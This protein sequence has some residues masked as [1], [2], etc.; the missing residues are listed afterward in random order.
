M[1]TTP[2]KSW[3]I[4]HG[5]LRVSESG[6]DSTEIKCRWKPH[7]SVWVLWFSSTGSTEYEAISNL[8]DEVKEFMFNLMVD[9]DKD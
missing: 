4:V 9:M 6:D 7:G 5:T 8:Y 1:M 2:S 3:F